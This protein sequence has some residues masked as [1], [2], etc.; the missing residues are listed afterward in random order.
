M[1]E[2]QLIQVRYSEDLAG[3]ADLRPVVRQ[4]MTLDEL[5][6]LVLA[7]TGK[8]PGRVR[9]HLRSGTC[10]YNI[11]RY[12]WEGFEIDDATLDAALARFPDPDPGRRFHA[13]DCLWVRFADNQ[14]PTPH[15]LTVERAEAARRRW[16]RRESL[17][18]FLLA[19]AASKALVYLDYSYYHRADLY[20]AELT[21]LDRSLLLHQARRLA[22]RALADWLG[23]GFA[24]ATLDAAC[25]RS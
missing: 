3:Y 18:D 24:W 13:A 12:W 6:G 4:A 9:A 17:W 20:R 14:E 7:T 22:P 2:P 23:R 10:T 5:L 1:P 25:R 19:L 21:A 8:H 16:F 15:T 11:F